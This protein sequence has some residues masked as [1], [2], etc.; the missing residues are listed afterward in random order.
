MSAAPLSNGKRPNALQLIRVCYE[1]EVLG[2]IACQ[3]GDD[4]PHKLGL[5][6]FW[7]PRR[8]WQSRFQERH[9]RIKHLRE[10]GREFLIYRKIDRLGIEL[11]AIGLGGH[12]YMPDGSS[13]GFNEDFKN[14]VKPGYQSQ[15]YGGDKRRA[16]LKVAYERGI[17]FF[18]VTIDPEKEA[19]GRNLKEMPPP[20]DIFIQTRPEGMGYGYDPNN[21]KM[22]D[23]ALLKAEV[24]RILQL[25]GRDY[26]DFLNFPF[27]QTALDADDEYIDKM[28]HNANQLKREGLIRF[29]TADNFSGEKTYLKQ[30]TAGCFDALAMNF[31]FADDGPVEN[32]L[33][34]AAEKGLAVITREV[35]QKG[36]LFKM[37][38][39][40]G[41][42][43]RDLLSR[44]ALKWNLAH[45]QATTSLVGA[46]DID[47]LENSLAVLSEPALSAEENDV[48]NKLR[49]APTYS[50]YSENRRARFNTI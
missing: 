35:F 4:E 41:I 29:A 33:P 30:A 47:H 14:A 12:E 9:G 2:E 43:D 11:S 39:E 32:V 24:Q 26:I 37:G 27:L 44:V 46:D 1:E 8:N 25:M 13:R 6:R 20:H 16:L 5:R 40:V 49:S 3:W 42:E 31:N 50:E 28:R 18:D 38:G 10:N 45:H 22:G 15:G 23:Y 19:L 21:Q 7:F 36:Q 17:N 48:L 34:I